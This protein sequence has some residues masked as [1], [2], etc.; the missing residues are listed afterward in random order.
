M[1]HKKRFRVHWFS[2]SA[3]YQTTTGK[4][5]FEE[6]SSL[7]FL[8]DAINFAR[9][10]QRDGHFVGIAYETRLSRFFFEPDQVERLTGIRQG[11]EYPTDASFCR[12]GKT[13]RVPSVETLVALVAAILVAITVASFAFFTLKG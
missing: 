5:P 4:F 12:F 10:L 8:D 3:F 1:F 7:Q 11:M 9:R 13:S 2:K 6:S